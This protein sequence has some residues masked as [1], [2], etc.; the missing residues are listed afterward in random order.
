MKNL[1]FVR[2]CG[3][4]GIED[5]AWTLELRGMYCVIEWSRFLCVRE[6]TQGR[7]CLLCKER[8]GNLRE[9][10]QTFFSP[11]KLWNSWP[12]SVGLALD[13]WVLFS[14]HISKINSI[15]NLIVWKSKQIII[16]KGLF[17]I[18]CTEFYAQIKGTLPKCLIQMI[19]LKNQYQLIQR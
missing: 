4:R 6:N 18:L 15:W 10:K 16:F 8:A 13:I 7:S 9:G 17:D 3:F 5:E 19:Q 14:Y 2:E 12:E 11:R 1:A